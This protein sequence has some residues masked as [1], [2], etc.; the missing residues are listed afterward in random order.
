M[1]SLAALAGLPSLE[2]TSA[3]SDPTPLP[4]D[5]TGK[6]APST[7][8]G[9]SGSSTAITNLLP[10]AG[11]SLKIPSEGVYIGDGIPP[12]PDKLATKIRRGEFVE[13]GDLLPEFW[14]LK[15]EDGEPNRDKPR[16][17]R[18]VTDIFTWL[19]CF[20]AYVSVR[21]TQAPLQSLWPTWP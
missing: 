7:P 3:Q 5:G 8:L 19:H 1:P 10:F 9:T 15:A 2:G 21:A 6:G 11:D 13:M 12:V 4:V 18:K 20:G 16:R 17:T 14:S